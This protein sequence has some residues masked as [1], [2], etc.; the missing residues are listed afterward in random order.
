LLTGS[1]EFVLMTPALLLLVMLT[2]HKSA[3]ICFCSFLFWPVW[4]G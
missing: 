2:N 1:Q 3:G 4:H